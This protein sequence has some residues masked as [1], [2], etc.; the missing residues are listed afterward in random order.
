M[1][2]AA[3]TILV[4]FKMGLNM[5]RVLILAVFTTLFG[6]AATPQ[7]TKDISSPDRSITLYEN[8]RS[9][10]ESIISKKAL[11]SFRDKYLAA[12]EHKA[13]A[14]SLSGAWDW[15]SSR[16]SV[17]HAKTSAL[18]GCQKN[19]RQV[20]DLYPCRIINVNGEW[21]E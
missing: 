2:D 6:C 21:T 14:Q 13:F 18:V 15:K 16:T 4:K 11:A 9:G 1:V 20:E 10:P 5:T 12:G 8:V 3:L 17:E 7:D 19:N